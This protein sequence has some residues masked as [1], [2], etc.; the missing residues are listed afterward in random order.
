MHT[1]FYLCADD[2]VLEL[3]EAHTHS[4]AG[5]FF[6]FYLYLSF[7][8]STEQAKSRGSAGL[9]RAEAANF[10]WALWSPAAHPRRLNQR[11]SSEDVWEQKSLAIQLWK[12]GRICIR[13]LVLNTS[14]IISYSSALGYRFRGTSKR[15]KKGLIIKDHFWWMG[16]TREVSNIWGHV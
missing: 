15:K 13:V 8:F 3:C 16:K 10:L 5:V 14:S 1:E 2:A 11:R 4:I 7:L 6:F 9:W 12:K